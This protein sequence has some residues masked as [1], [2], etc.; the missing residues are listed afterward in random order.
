MTNA[1]KLQGVHTVSLQFQKFTT[2]AIY[3][4]SSSD[5]FHVLGGYQDFYHVAFQVPC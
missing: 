1:L 5:L 4:I 3:E 2:K